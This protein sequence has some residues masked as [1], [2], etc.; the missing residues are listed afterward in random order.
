MAAVIAFISQKGGVGKA[1]EAGQV[2]LTREGQPMT[3]KLIL[4]QTWRPEIQALLAA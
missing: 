2:L 1:Q 3:F 4:D